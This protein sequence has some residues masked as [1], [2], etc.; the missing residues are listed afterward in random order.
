MAFVVAFIGWTAWKDLLRRRAI[1][2]YALGIGLRSA[3]GVI[4]TYVPLA[5]AGANGRPREVTACYTGVRDG[6]E[7]AIYDLRIG[8]GKRVRRKTVV[9]V[10]LKRPEAFVPPSPRTLLGFD[11]ERQY[12]WVLV[13]LAATRDDAN[14][15]EGVL[16][17][18]TSESQ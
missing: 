1:R 18:L 8:S 16:D 6:F 17:Y 14:Q 11:Y 3:E 12:A 2:R 13:I 5:E 10:E 7:I 15:I 4:P 9:C